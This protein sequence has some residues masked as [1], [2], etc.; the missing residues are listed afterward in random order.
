M[1]KKQLDAMDVMKTMQRQYIPKE[2]Q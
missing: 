2:G 1:Y